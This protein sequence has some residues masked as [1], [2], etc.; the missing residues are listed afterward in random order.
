MENKTPEIIA[1]Y[2]DFLKWGIERIER[3]P[4]TQRYSFGTQLQNKM[5]RI[6]EDLIDAYY[7]RDK[8]ELLKSINLDFEIL[9]YYFRLAKD[10]NWITIKQYDFAIKSLLDIGQQLGGWIKQQ[11]R[12]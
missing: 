10:L 2:Y 3:M 8:L 12:A 11:T 1:K 7:R 5:V 4:K 9:R 6:L